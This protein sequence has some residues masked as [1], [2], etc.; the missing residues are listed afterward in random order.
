M[1]KRRFDWGRL[2]PR[3]W[4]QSYPTDWE[5]DALLNELLDAELPIVKSYYTVKIGAVDIWTGNYP[6]AFG[7]P[8]SPSVRVLPSTATRKRLRAAIPPDDPMA[9]VR[10]AM[11][12][13]L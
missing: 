8:Y 10:T 1:T 5:W 11:K 7:Q 3:F 12:A 9:D 4:L 2:H 6:Y 13:S